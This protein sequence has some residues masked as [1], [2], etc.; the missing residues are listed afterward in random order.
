MDVRE[1]G[2]K[3]KQPMND[4]NSQ[5]WMELALVL[6]MELA[7]ELELELELELF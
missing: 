6:E 1:A 7:L 5:Q 4:G 3:H 2:F